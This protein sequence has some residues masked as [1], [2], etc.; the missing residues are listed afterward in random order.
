[1]VAVPY[2]GAAAMLTDLMSGE[3]HFMIG[4]M[5]SAVPFF[6]ADKIRAI[7]VA[8]RQRVPGFPDIPAVAETLP[9][10]E[11]TIWYG[12]MAPA[13]TPEPVV[14]QLSAEL[15]VIGRLPDVRDALAKAGIESNPGS[16]PEMARTIA[17]E[18][19]KWGRVIRAA[20]IQPQ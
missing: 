13:G 17:A 15:S 20:G 9:G 4:A 16:A 12:M 18:I 10:Y 11:V 2:K 7:G 19:E 5:N 6:K 14:N 8:E 1:M 3:V